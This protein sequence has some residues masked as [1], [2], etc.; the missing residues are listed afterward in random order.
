MKKILLASLSRIAFLLLSLRY[1]IEFRG[2]EGLKERLKKGEGILF[3]P[4][5]PSEIEPLFLTLR[6]WPHFFFR[7]IAVEYA[8]RVSFLRPILKMMRAIPIPK[9]SVSVNPIKAKAALAAIDEASQTLKGGG[10]LLLYPA[11][12]LKSGAKEVIGGT[13]AVHTLLSQF[14]NVNVVLIRVTGLWGSSFSQ[15]LTG[16]SPHVTDVCLF[17][18]KALLKNGLFFLPRRKVVIELEANPPDFPREKSRV[19][20]NQYLENW[21]NRSI[22][23]LQIVPYQFWSRKKPAP[24]VRSK[25][26]ISGGALIDPAIQEKIYGEIRRILDD[27]ELELTFDKTLTGDL[28]MDSLNI[29]ELSAYLIHNFE[30][31]NFRPED[32]ATSRSDAMGTV[33]DVLRVAAG[34]V[35]TLKEPLDEE[36]K[37]WPEEGIRPD[38]ISPQGK[39]IPEAFLSIC[40]RM[41][42]HAA[43]NDFTS[44]VASYSKLHRSVRV[45]A[46]YFQNFPEE[47]VAVMLPASVAAFA[48]VLALHYAGKVPVMLNWTL[49]SRYLD[50]MMKMSGAKEVISSH[51][52]IDRVSQIDFG[53]LAGKLTYLET[54]RSQLNW[55]TKLKGLFLSPAPIDPEAPAVLLFTSGSEALPKCVPLTHTNIL[56]NAAAAFEA[57]SPLTRTDANYSVLPPFHSF[58]FNCSGLLPLLSGVKTTF[59]PD[60]TNGAAIAG[61]IARTQSTLFAAPPSFIK[62]VFAAASPEQLKTIRLYISAAEKAPP[63]VIR[64]AESMGGE[65]LEGYGATECS[66]VV[67]LNRPRMPKKGVGRLVKGVEL[68]T[69]HPETHLPLPF[70]SEGEICLRGASIFKGYIG[71]KKAPFIEIDQ[72]L[73]YRTG[74]LG[75]LDVEGHLHLSGRLKR[76]IKMGGEMISLGVIEE[77]LAERLMKAGRI[78]PNIPSIAVSAKDSA[79]L[80]F[81]LIPLAKEE[82]NQILKTAGLSN[83]IKISAVKEVSEIP[84]MGTGKVDYRKLLEL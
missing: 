63:E 44:G 57:L 1:R 73:W 83:L 7:P 3:I 20:L 53:P 5:H 6:L 46:A 74:D 21:Y 30:V 67:A 32:L 56:S 40:R 18:L 26:V 64:Q 77:V 29:A 22:E 25:K 23:P 38:P 72:K 15:A 43:C 82:A 48:V 76:F 41:G 54:L 81:S 34:A 11:G 36:L 50:E 51:R 60:P 39:T 61:G 19:E 55:K 65:F 42:S 16:A 75:H 58:G 49:G 14:P 12:G 27:P 35:L 37:E 80:L 17:G 4:N 78:D 47:R 84:I 33:E 24:Y 52:F 31:G 8:F 13:S 45:L 69:L 70:G 59:Y 71:S 68:L 28:G 9:F 2:D 62:R 79:V 10:S 66:P